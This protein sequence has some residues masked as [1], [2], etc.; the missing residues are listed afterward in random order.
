M[1]GEALNASYDSSRVSS[2][3]PTSTSG[4]VAYEGRRFEGDAFGFE[5]CAHRHTVV[6]SNHETAANGARHPPDFDVA[7]SRFP[8]R[9]G[10]HE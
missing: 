6:G 5:H 2:I 7:M 4:G 9:A 1:G 10:I 8:P 3:G